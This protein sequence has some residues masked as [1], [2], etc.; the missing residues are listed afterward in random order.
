MM[1]ASRSPA[2]SAYICASHPHPHPHNACRRRRRAHNQ[3]VGSDDQ[4]RHAHG[5]RSSSL[6]ARS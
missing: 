4:R 1:C 2:T 6:V 3:S 5:T